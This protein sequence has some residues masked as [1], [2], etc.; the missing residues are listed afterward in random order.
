MGCLAYFSARQRLE[1]ARARYL[2]QPTLPALV[3]ALLQAPLTALESS[4]DGTRLL[5]LD[6]ETTGLQPQDDQILSIGTVDITEGRID[7][8]TA[9]Q[10]LIDSPCPV[11]ADTVIIHHLVPQLL[12]TGKSLDQ[13][14]DQLLQRM[15]GAIL[16]AHGSSVERRFIDHYLQQRH[17]LP[18][19][20]LPWLDTLEIERRRTRYIRDMSADLRLSS[21]RS[22]HGLPSYPCHEALIDAV[23]TAELLLVQYKLLRPA[24]L[25]QLM[26]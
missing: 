7:L 11:K 3:K 1:R 10:T 4:L 16:L 8:Q 23:A 22:R 9:R 17:G 14:M 20:P 12:A 26:R 15:S 24:S 6:F 5:A 19:L 21:V 25:H 18:P 2:T 13:A